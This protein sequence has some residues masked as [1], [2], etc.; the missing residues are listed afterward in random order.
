M[1]PIVFIPLANHFISFGV[2]TFSVFIEAELF[3]VFSLT[4]QKKIQ[5][6]RGLQL[7]HYLR[8]HHFAIQSGAWR[9]QTE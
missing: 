2:V 5:R 9:E 8:F 1:A 3:L 7:S 4:S 6:I